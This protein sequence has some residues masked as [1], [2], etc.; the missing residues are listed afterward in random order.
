[1][2]KP[3][4]NFMFQGMTLLF[5]LRDLLQPRADIVKDAGIRPGFHVLDFGCGPGAYT[6]SI[7][8]MVGSA[9]KV[10]AL[11]LHPLAIQRVQNL[12][13]TK[14]LANVETIL[15]D[16][17]TGLPD[18]SIDLVVLFDVYHMLQNPQETLA[19]FHRILKPGGQLSVLEP[20]MKEIKTISGVTKGKLFRLS[21][22]GKHTLQFVKDN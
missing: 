19:E 22:E 1:M 8:K 5:K 9:G 13:G 17:Q 3:M 18:R 14:N 11:D 2:D 21:G 15:V 7:S 20:H 16:D 12:I 6:E 4:P 10:Y